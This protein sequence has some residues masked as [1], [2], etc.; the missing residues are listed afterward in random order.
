MDGEVR[1][2]WNGERVV[3]LEL[4]GP[5]CGERKSVAQVE[6]ALSAWSPDGMAAWWLAGYLGEQ[7]RGPPLVVAGR[8][9]LG[10]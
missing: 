9:G 5:V 6:R 7:R 4:V 2:T 1:S 8:L 10:D 3:R